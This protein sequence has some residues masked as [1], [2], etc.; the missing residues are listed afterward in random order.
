MKIAFLLLALGYVAFVWTAVKV[1]R[2]RA[3]AAALA[4]AAQLEHDAIQ[5]KYFCRMTPAEAAELHASR[6]Q[7]D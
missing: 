2:A 4:R 3:T 5:A 7:G 6:W 1:A